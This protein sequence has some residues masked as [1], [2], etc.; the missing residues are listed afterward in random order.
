MNSY[1]YSSSRLGKVKPET[2]SISKELYD[3]ARAAGHE[4]WFM[5]GMGSS[6]EHSS[7][8]A[9][10]L[11]VRNKA[12]GDFVRN[13][14]WTH[15]KRLRLRHVIWWQK[16]TS[17]VVS[18]GVVR[19]MPDRGNDTKN[20]LDHVHVWFFPGTYKAPSV[21]SAPA[22]AQVRQI[23]QLVEVKADGKWG[24]ITDG[25][26]MLMRRACRS[27][28][29]YPSNW[30]DSF[31]VREVQS[32]IDAKQDDIWGPKSQA[33]LVEWIKE[34]QKILTTKSDGKWGNITDGRLLRARAKY[35]KK[36]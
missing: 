20:H 9:L 5:W 19:A 33:A 1:E 26:V 36:Y 30:N 35:F 29:G 11:M 8:N 32:I 15:R 22:N 4:I 10:D 21:V 28:A 16:I 7:G 24:S 27:K 17:T 2:K 13:Y 31:D 6:K 3:V 18:P 14:I 23:Q 34:F 25:R 12:A